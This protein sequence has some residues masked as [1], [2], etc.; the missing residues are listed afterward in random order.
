MDIQLSQKERMLLEDQKNHEQICIEKYANYAN[1]CSD[2]QLKQIFN[3]NGQV[4]Q[5]H[6]N[7]I[8]QLLSGKL[9]QTGQQQGQNQNQSQAQNQSGGQA[10]YQNRVNQANQAGTATVSQNNVKDM[11]TDMLMTEKYVS[12]AYD[13]SIFEFQDTR[14]RDVLNHIQKEEQKHGEAI[15]Q[16]MNSKGL[17]QPQ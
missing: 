4:E 7:S 5:E 2:T 13:T 15:F 9:P 8:N 3:A 14:V 12:G 10:G 16:Y 6:L 17:Y 11:C 1:Q